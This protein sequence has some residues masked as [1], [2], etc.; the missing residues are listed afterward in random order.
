MM[1]VV[2]NFDR[3]L[4]EAAAA[5]IRDLADRLERLSADLRRLVA[6]EAP[7]SADLN[8]APLLDQYAY[9][10]RSEPCLGGLATGHPYVAPGHRVFTSGV[11]AI[12]ESEG[13]ARTLS[14]FWKLG[15]K[16]WTFPHGH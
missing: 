2:F 7:T 12:S 8:M 9:T 1:V 10:A 6:G 3:P 13:W 5:E 15:K 4:T 16:E 11:Y 14:R